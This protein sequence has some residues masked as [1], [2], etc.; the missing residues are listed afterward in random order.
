MSKHDA[1][2][3]YDF[4]IAAFPVRICFTDNQ[5]NGTWL[6]PS[7]RSFLV[8]A[9]SAATVGEPLFTLIVDDTLPVVPKEHRHRIRV[10]DTGNGDTAVDRLEDGGYQFIIKDIEHNE[11]AL[12]IADKGFTHCRCA[13]NGSLVR[14][15]GV[16]YAFTAKSGTGKST[17]VS[18][19]MQHIPDCDIMN[20]DNPIIRLK[21]DGVY[22]YGGPWS[23]KTPCS[24]LSTPI[25][26]RPFRGL[27]KAAS[28]ARGT[29]SS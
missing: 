24:V 20:D 17:H 2:M 19:W 9:A 11:C 13:L 27:S 21:D 6:I 8:D 29:G 18:L 16:A 15:E 26:R 12:L 3:T 14:H 23:G 10:F 7:L 28:G 25:R 1:L 22:V 4:L 5:P